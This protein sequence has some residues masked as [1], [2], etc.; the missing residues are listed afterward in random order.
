MT[1][2]DNSGGQ[3]AFTQ[4]DLPE[5]VKSLGLPQPAN[6]AIDRYWKPAWDAIKD[7][8]PLLPIHAG[9]IAPSAAA[10]GGISTESV[11]F[12][13]FAQPKP[14]ERWR[15][16]F[17]EMWPAYRAWYLREGSDVRPDLAT[18]RQRLREH[19]PELVGT[20]KQLVELAGDDEVA[21]RCLSLY[22]PP[23]FIVGCSQGVWTRDKPML[24]RNYDYPAARLEGIIYKTNWAGQQIIGMSDCLWGL[25]D[26]LNDAGLA[27]S[28]TFGGRRAVGDGFAIPLVVRYLLETCQNVRQARGKL[29]RL[30]IHAAQNLSLLDR[31]GEHLTAYLAPDRPARFTRTPATTNHQGS[32]DWPEY[33]N[34]VRSVEREQHLLALLG[35]DEITPERFVEAFLEPPLYNTD[36]ASGM[37]TLYTA[38]Y[39][40]TERRVEYRWPGHTIPQS[41]DHFNDAQHVQTFAEH[42]RAT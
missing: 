2:S 12:E 16:N 34:A 4:R 29:E 23:A 27:V 6:E 32:I 38:A 41:F 11:N 24:V 15:A 1:Q 35:T 10:G 3:P 37:G 22:R 17:H 9:R 40:P 14:A 21:A 7:T 5:W 8:L 33:A 31:S 25:L 26:G 28:L 39:F 20:Y 13:S 42:S 30:P 19:M 18:C 36:Y